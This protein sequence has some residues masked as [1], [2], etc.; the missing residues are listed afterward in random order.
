MSA[1][2]SP[3]WPS[4]LVPYPTVPAP[5][6]RLSEM[7]ERYEI[8][9]AVVSTGP[10]AVSATAASVANEE[11]AELVRAEPDRFAA[12]ATLPLAEVDATLD[13]V[14]RGLD[15]L[16][17][18]G[19]LLVTNV[20]G[21][22]L[23]Q[24]VFEP[25]LAELDRRGAYAF[26]H[27]TMPPYPL[28]LRHPGWLYEFPFETTRALANC[29]YEGVFE[30]YP[31]IRFQISHLGG[32]APFLAYRLASLAD[33]NPELALNAP[34]GA[35]EY[36]QRLFYDTGLANNKPALAGT[37]QVTTLDHVVFGTDWPFAHLPDEGNDL[38]PSSGLSREE[39]EAVEE[40]NILALVDRWAG[41]SE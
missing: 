4:G 6:A 3:I 21:I 8:D 41:A 32:T 5:V 11:L 19:V 16:G 24:P 38:A 22:Y 10:A 25:L 34:A 9:R 7:M 12:L 26:V 31:R 36:L 39:R 29:I 15:E 23:G 28:P 1:R 37:L 14:G 13:E 27:P 40:R 30:R 20:A 35:L 2:E 33:R 17:L 18:D